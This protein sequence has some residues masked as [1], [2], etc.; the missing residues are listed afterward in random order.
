MNK[1]EARAER[2]RLQ[3]LLDA[4]NAGRLADH[5]RN[6]RRGLKRDVIPDRADKVRARIAMLDIVIAE[7]DV[8]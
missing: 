6:D 3:K 4:Y 5:E 1:T 7:P 8:A 2:A